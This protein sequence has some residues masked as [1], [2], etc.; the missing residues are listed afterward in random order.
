MAAQELSTKH[1]DLVKPSDY[2]HANPFTFVANNPMRYVDPDGN[3]KKES[4]ANKFIALVKDFVNNKNNSY[5]LVRER[6]LRDT[7]SRCQSVFMYRFGSI[8]F[9]E[10]ERG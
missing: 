6:S 10:D 8:E 9:K 5:S 7:E 2:F 1:I 3:W 4:N